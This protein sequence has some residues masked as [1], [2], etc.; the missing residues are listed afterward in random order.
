VNDLL[1][2][3]AFVLA[4]LLVLVVIVWRYDVGE[5]EHWQRRALELEEE[6]GP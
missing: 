1:L 4:A 6:D 2:I 5:L 3:V